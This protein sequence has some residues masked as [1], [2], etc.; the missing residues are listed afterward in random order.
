LISHR[1]TFVQTHDYATTD[2]RRD[3]RL[4]RDIQQ[5][6]SL[7]LQDVGLAPKEIE[8]AHDESEAAALA[9]MKD[10]RNGVYI[11]ALV[12]TKN[13]RRGGKPLA[14]PQPLDNVGVAGGRQVTR[15]PFSADQDVVGIFPGEVLLASRQAEAAIHKRTGFEIEL[16]NFDGV[17]PTLRE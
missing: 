5:L 13:L 8:F 2:E 1:P 4:G 9:V 17:L 3:V 10:G 12:A 7:R 16:A 11:V 15:H 14:A 6:C